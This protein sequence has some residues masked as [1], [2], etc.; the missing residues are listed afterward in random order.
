M[1]IAQNLERIRNQVADACARAHRPEAE[2]SL[3]AVSKVHPVE[4]LLEAHASGQR[5]FGEN[6]VQEWAGQGRSRGRT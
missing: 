2:V 4:A 6:R 1:S 5:L 3:M